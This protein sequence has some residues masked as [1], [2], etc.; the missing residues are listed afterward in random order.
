MPSW[1]ISIVI[2]FVLGRLS[3]FT[4]AIDWVKTQHDLDEAIRKLIPGTWFDDAAVAIVDA[5]LAAIK[6]VLGSADQLKPV[7]ELL[8]AHK[9]MEAEQMLIAM[10]KSH[11]L[12]L[13]LSVAEIQVKDF[14]EAQV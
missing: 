3:V 1:I 10:L 4:H 5:A 6:T 12:G 7:L 2:K 14:V 11:F 8:A 13:P 9:Y